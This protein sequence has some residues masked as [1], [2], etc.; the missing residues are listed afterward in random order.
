MLFEKCRQSPKK[1]HNELV[2]KKM[3][4]LLCKMNLD[5][6]KPE[7]Q[8]R[9]SGFFIFVFRQNDKKYHTTASGT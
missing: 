7:P 4:A 1:Q 2:F 3:A 9:D 5:R 6:K 8:V